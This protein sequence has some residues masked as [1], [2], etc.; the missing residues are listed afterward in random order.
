MAGGAGHLS[1]AHRVM[2][3]L[4]E[5]RVLRLMTRSADLNLRGC[6]LHRIFGSMQRVTTCTRYVARRVRTRCPVMGRVRLVTGQTLRVLFWRR[7][8]RFG[9]E[10]DHARQRAASRLYVRTTRPVTGLA[11][12]AAVAE[13]TTGIVGTRVRGAEQTRDAGIVMTAE[14]GVGTLRA[15]CRIGVRRSIGFG[16]DIG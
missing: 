15:E 1:L 8:E 6:G 16:C 14:T 3:G 4:Q 10:V 5:I 13:W 12:Q 7:R 11:L 2:R 9:S